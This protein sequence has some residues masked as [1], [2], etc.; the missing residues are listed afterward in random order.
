MGKI[1]R[2]NI[3]VTAIAKINLFISDTFFSRTKKLVSLDLFFLTETIL[4][5]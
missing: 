1:F 4:E 5:D 2:L 3:L